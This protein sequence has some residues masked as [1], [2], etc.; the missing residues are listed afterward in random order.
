VKGSSATSRVQGTRFAEVRW[1]DDTG[2][3]NADLLAAAADGVPE[4]LVLVADHQSAGR[5]RLDRTWTAPPGSSLLVSVLLRPGLAIEDSF[6]LNNAAGVAAVAACQEVAGVVPGLK[7]PND[8]VVMPGH[9]SS[10]RKL[11]GILAEARVRGVELEA[12][13]VGMGLNVNWPFELPGELADVAVALDHLAGHPIDREDLLV[14]WLHRLDRVLTDLDRPTGQA[15]LLERV[16]EVSATLGRS[17][18]IELPGDRPVEGQ[19]VDITDAGHLVVVPD[20]GGAPIDVS[21]GDV[22][23]LRVRGD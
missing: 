3:T 22:V 14:A 12:V 7:W 9:R 21:V 16:R 19:A 8:L 15:T 1:V 11:G 5:G 20:D 10:G 13:V 6:L 23:H 17:V 2:S 4:G 18:R